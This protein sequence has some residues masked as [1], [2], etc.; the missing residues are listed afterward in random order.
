MSSLLSEDR[1]PLNVVICHLV[2]SFTL[3]LLGA[4][5]TSD[6]SSLALIHL[7]SPTQDGLAYSVDE[8]TLLAVDREPFGI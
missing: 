2:I 6:S 8:K 7:K 1:E 4:E 3:R 5:E